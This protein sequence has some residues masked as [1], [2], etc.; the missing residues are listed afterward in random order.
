MLPSSSSGWPHVVALSIAEADGLACECE[1]SIGFVIVPLVQL[2]EWIVITAR[3]S[4]GCLFSCT[5]GSTRPEHGRRNGE[6]NGTMK[7]TSSSGHRQTGSRAARTNSGSRTGWWVR[8]RGRRRR[9]GSRSRQ[10]G[11]PARSREE[12]AGAGVDWRGVARP[13]PGE[14]REMAPVAERK[15]PSA[16]D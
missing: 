7:L 5:V 10:R 6:G 12:S 15:R 1:L 16:L 4:P 11:R 3:S 9:A 2:G 14:A 13:R 8:G